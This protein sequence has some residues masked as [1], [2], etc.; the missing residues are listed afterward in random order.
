MK[1]GA[2]IILDEPH[3][4][5]ILAKEFDFIEVYYRPDVVLEIDKWPL[6]IKWTVHIPHAS[7]TSNWFNCAE[8]EPKS[9]IQNAIKSMEFA[10]KIGA[11][12]VIVHPGTIKKEDKP[13]KFMENFILNFD[14][15]RTFAK[16]LKLKL[17]IETVPLYTESG[18]KHLISKPD[19]YAEIIKKFKL[20]LCLDFSHAIHAAY[21]HKIPYK[22]FI[23][24][25]MKLKPKY[26]HLYDTKMNQELDIHLPI[27]DGD[28][29]F[30]FVLPLIKNNSV[31]FEMP[32]ENRLAN[33]LNAKKYLINRGFYK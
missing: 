26:F 15:L 33:Y 3:L 2:K 11:K 14:T 25:F 31:A 21:S 7:G 24:D 6:H 17:L 4:V 12:Q 28:M 9:N 1:I 32:R 27:G 8:P 13:E 18:N 22:D 10:N 19:E 16:K 5:S 29:D 30:S 20:G 23:L